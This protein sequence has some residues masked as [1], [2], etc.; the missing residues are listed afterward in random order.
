MSM[1]SNPPL[2]AGEFLEEYIE[3]LENLPS[4]VQQGLQELGKADAQYF[5]L[6]ES[7]RA[8]WKKYIKSAKRSSVPSEEDPTLVAA[9]LNIEIEYRNAIRK[10]DQKIDY[11]NKLYELINRQI[12]R[13]DDEMLRLGIDLQDPVEVKK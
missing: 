2:T 13:L 11:A 8:H 6:R 5:D 7:Y 10:V 1:P 3:S 9:R 12:I 4:E